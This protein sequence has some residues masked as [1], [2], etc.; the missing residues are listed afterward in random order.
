MEHNEETGETET[1][2]AP[3]SNQ[4]MRRDFGGTSLA[5]GNQATEALIAKAR[6]DVEARWVMAMRNPRDVDD[7]RQMMLQECRRNGFAQQAIYSI[8]IGGN[9]VEGLTIRFAEVA[10]RCWGNMPIET[11]TIYD[12]GE[13]RIVRVTVTDL[14]SNVTWSRDL[15]IKKTIE[16]KQVKRG[17]PVRGQRVNSYG[18][19]VYI[20]DATDDEIAV[21]EAA[22]VS[23]AA[24]TGILRLI[25]GHI[26]DEM[27][28]LCKKLQADKNAKDPDGERVRMLDAF[29]E[30]RI[31]PS[32]LEQWLGHDT[33]KLV[34]AELEQLR[35]LYAAIR[36]GEITWVAALAAK[37]ENTKPKAEPQPTATETPKAK[38]GGAAGLKDQLKEQPTPHAG[39]DKAKAE[40]RE[41]DAERAK[42]DRISTDEQ[43]CAKC[44]VPIEPGEVG[45]LCYACERS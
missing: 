41:R 40:A 20:V 30:L 18:D 17:Q 6:A 39:L 29:A 43:A 22:Q 14:E 35:Q 36:E 11:Q 45:K 23:K 42:P 16:R 44:G 4:S 21:K 3:R 34:P 25:P 28:D 7:S 10:A 33:S 5:V 19:T 38:R 8:P 26:Q 31:M 1:A 27:F 2:L 32:D 13:E 24:R 9:K 15:T 12:S 37:L